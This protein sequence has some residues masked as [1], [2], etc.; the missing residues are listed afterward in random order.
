MMMKNY[1]ARHFY[2][3]GNVNNFT[4]SM[5]QFILRDI[6]IYI[7]QD[8]WRGGAIDH[9][10]GHEDMYRALRARKGSGLTG[11]KLLM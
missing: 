5:G 4:F 8:S 11:F 3:P 2:L 9:I 7:N 1:S 6:T 10:F